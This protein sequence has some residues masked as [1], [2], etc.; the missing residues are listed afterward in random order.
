MVTKKGYY[1]GAS[2]KREYWTGS[3]SSTDH[4][5]SSVGPADRRCY[6]DISSCKADNVCWFNGYNRDY[7]L[8]RDYC[9]LPE[10]AGDGT[11]GPR[12]V[13]S[14]T[15]YDGGVLF[16]KTHTLS[17][18]QSND[19]Q[20][21]GVH[22]GANNQNRNPGCCGSSALRKIQNP[23][24]GFAHAKKIPEAELAEY[25]TLQAGAAAMNGAG[26]YQ[27]QSACEAANRPCDVSPLDGG[28]APANTPGTCMGKDMP[29]SLPNVRC[30]Q[31][32]LNAQVKGSQ[33][34][35]HI[36][37]STNCC[38]GM[39][40]SADWQCASKSCLGYKYPPLTPGTCA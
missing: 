22:R 34:A 37:C 31:A 5:A 2:G 30:G 1:V 20:M 11:S 8:G 40:C 26:C 9:L 18:F 25:Y 10:I 24:Q 16:P 6:S 23:S 32:C 35:C 28:K 13:S 39:M 19:Y 36:D 17:T 12:G 27:T 14:N 4:R 33:V 7:T 29:N 3:Y 38:G 15:L 21:G